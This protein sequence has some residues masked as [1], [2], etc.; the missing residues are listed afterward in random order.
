MTEK[1]APDC[2]AHESDPI[3]S[4]SLIGLGGLHVIRPRPC[5]K[6]LIIQRCESA[7]VVEFKS[8]VIN[9]PG[10]S[11]HRAG[12]GGCLGITTF[13]KLAGFAI[14]QLKTLL[15]AR[16]PRQ[17]IIVWQFKKSQYLNLP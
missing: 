4:P 8:S 15:T 16:V 6:R 12:S 9:Y 13:L 10:A 3:P 11:G 14:G 17:T 2:L 1:H 7:F 5:P